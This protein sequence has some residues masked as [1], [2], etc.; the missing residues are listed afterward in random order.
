MLKPCVI[1]FTN[2]QEY[3][4]KSSCFILRHFIDGIHF[5]IPTNFNYWNPLNKFIHLQ[6][7]TNT[8]C[9]LWKKLYKTTKN[10]YIQL[11]STVLTLV[12]FFVHCTFLFFCV[13]AVIITFF[14]ACAAHVNKSSE[15][16]E[17]SELD[18]TSALK[19]QLKMNNCLF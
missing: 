15:L 19:L 11:G 1:S 14:W 17:V 10:L 2:F 18:E 9:Y 13:F 12:I 3:F 4:Q 6:I 8:Y 16:W 5:K 7:I